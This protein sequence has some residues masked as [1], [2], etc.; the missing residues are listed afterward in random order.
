MTMMEENIEEKIAKEILQTIKRLNLPYKLDAITQGKGDCFP[1]A[2]IAQCKR[3]EIYTKL[4]QNIQS[5]ILQDDP[6]KFRRAVRN[7]IL[8]SENVNI[9]NFREQYEEV[10]APIDCRNWI[11]YWE[12]MVRQYEWIDYTFVQSTAWFLNHDIMI[13]GTSGTKKDPY[14]LVS[15]NV[16]DSAQSHSTI[17]L[18]VGCKSNSHYQSLLP[19]KIN[20]EEN[21]KIKWNVNVRISK[22][23]TRAI[24]YQEQVI[25][26]KSISS[27]RRPVTINPGEKSNVQSKENIKKLNTNTRA[28]YQTRSI[29][30][31]KEVIG[32]NSLAS[33]G[34]PFTYKI[35]KNY[36]I[37]YIQPDKKIRCPFC[38]NNF[39]VIQC[40]LKRSP[41][42]VP[43]L[44][45]FSSRLQNFLSEYFK[46]DIKQN[47]RE[48]KAKSNA[49]IRE[50]DAEKFKAERASR[51]ANLRAR[52]KQQDDEQFKKKQ[53]AQKAKSDAYL[54]DIDDEKFKKDQA[55]RKADSDTNLRINDNKNFKSKQAKRKAISDA[56][57][58]ISD[59]LK[60]KSEQAKRKAISDTNLRCTDNEKFKSEQANR[61]AISDANLRCTDNEKFKSKQSKRKATSD[62]NLRSTDNETFKSEQTK[63]KAISNA[64]LRSTDS[65]KFK[66]EKA[67]SKANSD[68]HLRALDNETFKSE[69]AKRKRLS[70]NKKKD[71]DPRLL[72]ARE[73]EAQ[74]KRKINWNEKDRLRN[75]MEATK[76][77]AIFICNCCHRRL[78]HETVEIMTQKLRMIINAKKN[79]LIEKCLG[80]RIE[81][82]INGNH[83]TYLCKTC[84][85][86]MKAGNIP[87][88]S[89]MNRLWLD[90]QEEDL[91][92][93]EL[94]GAMIGKNLIFEKIHQLPKSR[95]TVLSDRIINVPITDEDIINTIKLLPRTP[96][97]AGLIGV[98]LKRKLEFKNTHTRQL[99]D[100]LKILKT[101]QRLREAGNPYYQFHDTYNEFKERCRKT[102][103]E[104]FELL[105]PDDSEEDI[106]NISNGQQPEVKNEIENLNHIK[107]DMD[108]ESADDEEDLKDEI[109]YISND[110]VRKFQFDYNKSVCLANRY[111]E[112]EVTDTTKDIVIAPGEGKRPYDITK[113]I[114]WDIKA[115]PHLHN[116]DGNNGKD[117]ERKINLSDQSYFIQ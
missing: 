35:G 104:G 75:F 11:Q 94:E 26:T 8:H 36:K 22:A 83:D 96:T 55:R 5:I 93:T 86:H 108:I 77:N 84:I 105:F 46:E 57:L 66:S 92:L 64:N 111:P 7:F 90:K 110:P 85:T 42:S 32:T 45:D 17:P 15:G 23:N 10:V 1:L 89:V 25:E 115:F 52:Q 63:R 71:Y 29:H 16:H 20:W 65:E 106:E 79:G 69:Q 99:V 28:T 61:K 109:D 91:K 50:K 33:N 97:E 13:I 114:D 44:S 113:D 80:E 72:A 56:N 2:I 54:R 78:F 73:N 76:Y 87:P 9:K 51:Q 103:P 34:I 62:A 30:Q 53:A 40:H 70:R 31:E 116:L 24:H 21:A 67:K 112:V 41:C 14:I 102:D 95:W 27:K 82:P 43:N 47:Q 37:F 74:K 39:K 58:R 48:R 19:V 18:V 98:S 38:S 81:T 49:K 60:F 4:P 100:P 59:N 3:E 6:T 117:T 68:A 12:V 101:L 88:M 107:G